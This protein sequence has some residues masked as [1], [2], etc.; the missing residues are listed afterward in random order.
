MLIANLRMGIE[1]AFAKA[2]RLLKAARQP[3]IKCQAPA[4]GEF[5]MGVLQT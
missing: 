1:T 4:T 5:N 2:L 3:R